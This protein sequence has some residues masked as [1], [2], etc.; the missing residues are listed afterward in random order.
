VVIHCGDYVA[1]SI[2][3]VA[4]RVHA[5]ILADRGDWC[6]LSPGAAVDQLADEVRMAVVPGVLL[7]H[8]DVHPPQV[9]FGGGRYVPGRPAGEAVAHTSLAT[10]PPRTVTLHEGR[11]GW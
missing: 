10:T 9:P 5:V 11:L 3:G 6:A 4:F 8:V 2:I 1:Q 7:D